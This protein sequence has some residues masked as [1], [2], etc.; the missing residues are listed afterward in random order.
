MQDIVF[1]YLR[2]K[3]GVEYLDFG[4]G[5]LTYKIEATDY[6]NRLC[7]C[8][9]DAYS[10]TSE[11]MVPRTVQILCDIY[12]PY[13][14]QYVEGYVDVKGKHKGR[15]KKMM[16]KFGMRKYKETDDFIYMIKRI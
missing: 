12:K 3:S 15:I 7:L 13:G 6:N 8:I 2:N 1:R 9:Y 16:N 5:F 4:T 14:I 10:E 11:E